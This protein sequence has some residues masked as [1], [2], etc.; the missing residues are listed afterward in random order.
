MQCVSRSMWLL[1]PRHL[2]AFRGSLR[3]LWLWRRSSIM[4]QRSQVYK[5]ETVN[6]GTLTSGVVMIWYNEEQPKRLAVQFRHHQSL[7]NNLN[8]VSRS[9]AHNLMSDATSSPIPSVALASIT[10]KKKKKKPRKTPHPK[11]QKKIQIVSLGLTIILNLVANSSC[12]NKHSYNGAKTFLFMEN[13]LALP[14]QD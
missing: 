11:N 5:Y 1:W 14:V 4:N 3:R 6:S 13:V 7:K 2:R 10:K 12:M 8:R 9:L